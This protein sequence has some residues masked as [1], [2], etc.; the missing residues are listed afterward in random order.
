VL[1]FVCQMQVKTRDFRWSEI[2][3]EVENLWKE[4]VKLE[5][6][7]KFV[8]DLASVGLLSRVGEGEYRFS[9]LTLQA[10][11]KTKFQGELPTT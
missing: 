3:T 5:D 1:A 9:H 8:L 2:Q 4:A 6:V 10:V 7:S 11:C